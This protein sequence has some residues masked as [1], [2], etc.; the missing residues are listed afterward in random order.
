MQPRWCGAVAARRPPFSAASRRWSR[1]ARARDSR[2]RTVNAA[3]AA[4]RSTQA[5][6]SGSPAGGT[7][8]AGWP[9]AGCEVL[10][11][12]LQDLIMIC[13]NTRDHNLHLCLIHGIYQRRGGRAVAACLHPGPCCG[14]AARVGPCANLTGGPG[15][16]RPCGDPALQTRQPAAGY[17]TMCPASCCP[18]NHLHPGTIDYRES[19]TTRCTPF[20]MLSFPPQST[21]RFSLAE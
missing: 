7:G 12:P 16:C 6:G 2:P 5:E 11:T 21:G 18:R 13:P 3:A 8:R 19:A 17:S 1:T 4:G 9:R 14:A 10:P 15:A 20:I